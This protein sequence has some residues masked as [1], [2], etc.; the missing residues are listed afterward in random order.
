MEEAISQLEAQLKVGPSVVMIQ[1][2]DLNHVL[3]VASSPWTTTCSR[4]VLVE[5]LEAYIISMAR[6]LNRLVEHHHLLV[7][8]LGRRW[9][10]E[11]GGSSVN[12]LPD[13]V[14]LEIFKALVE[15]WESSP[16]ATAASRYPIPWTGDVDTILVEPSRLSIA[17]IWSCLKYSRAAG[18]HIDLD[19]LDVPGP[20]S[21]ANYLLNSLYTTESGQEAATKEIIKEVRQNWD[22]GHQDIFYITAMTRVQELA[23]ETTQQLVTTVVTS[24][25]RD[26]PLFDV[27]TGFKA[28]RELT[29]SV[30][31]CASRPS[32]ELDFP[33][34]KRL[35]LTDNLDVLENVVFRTPHLECLA[36]DGWKLAAVNARAR[37]VKWSLNVPQSFEWEVLTKIE[38][39]EELVVHGLLL[40]EEDASKAISMI[41]EMVARWRDIPQSLQVVRGIH[42]REQT[43]DHLEDPKKQ[44]LLVSSQS[45]MTARAADTISL[46]ETFQQSIF[47]LSQT[48]NGTIQRYSTLVASLMLSHKR[49]IISLPNE[50]ILEILQFLVADGSH[51]L[52]PLLLVNKRF[53][54]LVTSAPSLWCKISIKFD[55]ALQECNDLSVRYIEACIKNSKNFLLDV[56]LDMIDIP[57]PS[58]CAASILEVVKKEV[59]H[60]SDV[61]DRAIYLVREIDADLHNSAPFTRRLANFDALRHAIAGEEGIHMRRWR[62]FKCLLPSFLYL[63]GYSDF[64]T[65]DMIRPFFEYKMPNLESFTLNIPFLVEYAD[66]DVRLPDLSSIRHLNLLDDYEFQL[67]SFSRHLLTTAVVYLCEYEAGNMEVF[68]GCGALQELTI[69]YLDFLSLGEIPEDVELPSLR[70]LTLGGYV[71]TLKHVTFR[72]PCLEK[73][74]L[75]CGCE[76]AIPKVRARLVVWEPDERKKF[77]SM[78]VFLQCLLGEVKEIKELVFKCEQAEKL[79][80]A[81]GVVREMITRRDA[82]VLE[83]PLAT[84]IVSEGL[85][86]DVVQVGNN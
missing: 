86:I 23:S 9:E 13:E 43:L 38:G 48:L 29:I 21:C 75:R 20:Q 63:H 11:P 60:F 49:T 69:E 39:I 58:D 4:I 6:D 74:T 62:S 40:D 82:G 36:L 32:D 35:T 7:T 14:V 1:R 31:S 44:L 15:R 47:D 46:I 34:L 68:S 17:Y 22:G 56:D 77:D 45:S 51:R 54:A 64:D 65:G 2:P 83:T 42:R 70:K 24:C 3:S 79:S 85:L 76:E 30:R 78:A 33:T 67:A 73:L 72:T 26:E 80:I 53:H 5:R 55:Q 8:S 37:T 71:H 81:G 19:V 41:H 16:L 57:H 50:M 28:L 10:P 84:R 27:L 12:R 18:L 61:I 66:S 25:I 59:P 52:Q